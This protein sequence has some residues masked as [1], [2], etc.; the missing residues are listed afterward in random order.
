M[1]QVWKGHLL[2]DAGNQQLAGHHQDPLLHGV[3]FGRC[4]KSHPELTKAV[5]DNHTSRC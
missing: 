2:T 3:A 5:K 1:H 4:Q